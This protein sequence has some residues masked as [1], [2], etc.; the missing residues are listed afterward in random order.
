MSLKSR[1]TTWQ[2]GDV[3]TAASLNAEF[4]GAL[5]GLEPEYVGDQSADVTEMRVTVDPYPLATPSLPTTLQGE[6]HRIRYALAGILGETY[7]Y[8]DPDIALADLDDHSARHESG[9]AD[10]I[11]L[12]NLAAPEDNTDLDVTTSAHGLAPKVTAPAD[13]ALLNVYGI[14]QGET[15]V[16]MKAA[17]SATNDPST[18]AFSDTATRGSSLFFARAD[19]KHGMPATPDNATAWVATDGIT[20]LAYG[21]DATLGTSNYWARKDH[22]HGMPSG[23]AYA[24]TDGITTIGHNN[25]ATLGTS[26]Y[27][28]RKDHKHKFVATLDLLMVTTDTTNLDADTSK[29]GLCPKGDN[30]ALHALLGNLSWGHPDASTWDGAHKFVSSTLPGTSDGATNDIWFQYEA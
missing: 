27:W 12:D 28:A 8:M 10:E 5:D 17:F 19:H 14:T 13:A 6:I 11:L 16:S 25:D 29:H 1:V 18:Q 21:G 4:D 23:T 26:Y 22:K 15:T 9:G 20:D 7:W 24:A 3:L 30:S 2:E